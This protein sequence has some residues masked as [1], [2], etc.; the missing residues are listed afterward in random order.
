MGAVLFALLSAV[1]FGSLAVTLNFA[2]RRAPD[3]ELGAF[4]T[5][6][7]SLVPV[8]LVA[9]ARSDW[10]GK[11]WPY[12]LAGLLAPGCSQLAYVVAVRDAGS[13]RTALV[14][15][16]APLVSVTLALAAFGEPVSAPL[17]A[18]AILIV[19]G[20]AALVSERA[21]PE[22]FRAIGL[23]FAFA[24]AVFF[25]TRDNV[26]RKLATDDHVSPELAALATI[27]AGGVVIAA[28]LVARR[29][30]AGPVR[31]LLPTFLAFAPS[32]IV[33]GLSYVFLFEAFARGRVSVVS[34]L[35]AIESLVG[36]VLAAVVLRRSELVGRH[37]WIGAMLIV[38]GG[39]LIGAFR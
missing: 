3:P 20:G 30:P 31:G 34:P 14:V 2:L 37:L 13:S 24:S 39:A 23:A 32:G 36:V 29:G 6:L 12:L 26:V 28:Y 17:V 22:A 1:C 25:A 10:G 4:A 5:V 7:W 19:L 9:V 35:V 38:A 21:R 33:W 8:G 27:I 11:V 15:G 16:A 18:G